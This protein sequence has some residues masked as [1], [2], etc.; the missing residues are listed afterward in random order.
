MSQTN[1]RGLH[2]LFD[3]EL[4]YLDGMPPV[5]DVEDAGTLVGSGTGR[6]DG[7]R[8]SCERRVERRC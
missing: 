3:A 1:S 8:L 5:A 7:P 2:Y 6:I 4:H